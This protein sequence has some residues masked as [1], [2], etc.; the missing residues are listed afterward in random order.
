MIYAF[1]TSRLDYCNAILCGLSKNQIKKLQA[2]QNTAA[3]L[4][5]NLYKYE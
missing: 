5:I 3:H 1:I 2:I 4:V